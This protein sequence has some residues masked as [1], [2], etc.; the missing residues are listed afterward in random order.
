MTERP[1]AV[2]SIAPSSEALAQDTAH[3]TTGG[4]GIDCRLVA[5]EEKASFAEDLVDALNEAVARQQ[6]QIESLA[7]ELTRL[8]GQVSELA[9]RDSAGSPGEELPPHY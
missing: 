7:R 9:E 8:R 5:L 3:P 2:P 6:Q 1:A 4:T